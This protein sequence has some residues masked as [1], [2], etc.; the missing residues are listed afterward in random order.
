MYRRVN[1][2][3][4]FVCHLGLW[5]LC[6]HNFCIGYTTRCR[7]LR[8]LHY[9]GPQARGSVRS[10]ETEPRCV[11]DL[12]HGPCGHDNASTSQLQQR[13]L[14][15]G[16]AG[17]PQQ[18]FAFSQP[19]RMLHT[20]KPLSSSSAV[21]PRW[22]ANTKCKLAKQLLYRAVEKSPTWLLVTPPT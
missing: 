4:H 21:K 2:E 20:E 12:Y 9:R 5:R 16:L 14:V 6:R 3:C 17:R 10:V 7:S 22:P 11:T 18:R 19:S 15:T 13:W 8:D 1:V